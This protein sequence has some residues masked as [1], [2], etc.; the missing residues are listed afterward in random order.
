[1][2]QGDK[3]VHLHLYRSEE[4]LM[5]F[6]FASLSNM[7]RKMHPNKIGICPQSLRNFRFNERRFY[8]NKFCTIEL[9]T[10]E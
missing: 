10:L 6:Y 8:A 9:I 1:M 7:F 3:I 2:K 5:D 4:G